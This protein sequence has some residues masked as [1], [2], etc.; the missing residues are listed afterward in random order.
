MA[1]TTPP[2][3]ETIGGLVHR[4]VDDG[5]TFVRAEIDV[6]K[7]SALLRVNRL[8]PGIIKVAA[9]GVLGL[10]GAVLLFV[11]IAIGVGDL[12]DSR[13]WGF[14][15]VSVVTLIVALILARMGI[16]GITKANAQGG[17]V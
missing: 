16:N 6:Q 2:A 4:L 13:F 14:A 12:I 17:N 1:S 5:R 7:Q 11:A 9:G 8:K 15:I 10:I 3:D